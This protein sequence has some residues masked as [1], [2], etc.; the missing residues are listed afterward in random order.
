MCCWPR[1]PL[2]NPQ[3]SQKN[4]T[5]SDYEQTQD[6]EFWKFWKT[7]TGKKL[8]DQRIHAHGDVDH[9]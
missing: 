6:N 4:Q 5:S 7:E 1:R 9:V 8:R 2:L 3:Q